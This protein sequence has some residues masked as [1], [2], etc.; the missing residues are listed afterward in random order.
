MECLHSDNNTKS[1]AHL[2]LIR[3]VIC[4]HFVL[5]YQCQGRSRLIYSTFTLEAIQELELPDQGD[6]QDYWRSRLVQDFRDQY[7]C[8]VVKRNDEFIGILKKN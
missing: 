6:K 3:M 7:E 5:F 4:F 1:G 8:H 2:I